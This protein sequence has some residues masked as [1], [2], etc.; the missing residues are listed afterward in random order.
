MSSMEPHGTVVN[1]KQAYITL[2][3]I[4]AILL[5]VHDSSSLLHYSC[6]SALQV[7]PLNIFMGALLK[8]K[9]RH[10]SCG[11]LSPS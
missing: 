10:R 4:M 9:G 8:S 11:V 3:N 2:P 7:Q 5:I 1:R 6:F